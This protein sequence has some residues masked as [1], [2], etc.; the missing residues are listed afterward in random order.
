MATDRVRIYLTTGYVGSG[1]TPGD[2]TE[3][4]LHTIRAELLRHA[5][6]E[7]ARLRSRLTDA[8]MVGMTGPS[9]APPQVVIHNAVIT[10]NVGGDAARLTALENAQMSLE[11]NVND[12]RA[13]FDAFKADVSAALA[14]A[15]ATVE[16]ANA[17]LAAANIPGATAALVTLAEDIAAA[18]ALVGDANADGVPAAPAPEVPGDDAPVDGE[19]VDGGEV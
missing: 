18:H 15:A 3:A 1:V 14:N 16:A 13:E 6:A 9:S 2:V 7:N 10:V 8:M 12:L 4:A 11:E 19:V 17:A 5:L